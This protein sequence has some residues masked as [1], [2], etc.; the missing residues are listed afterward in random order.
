[1]ISRFIDFL[2]FVYTL[3][4]NQEQ[5]KFDGRS[6]AKP[7]NNCLR[8]VISYI[9]MG[10][11]IERSYQRSPLSLVIY[12]ERYFAAVALTRSIM[13]R[14]FCFFGQHTALADIFADVIRG[15]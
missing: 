9:S 14:R 12:S 4:S 6:K 10:P 7:W 13:K 15:R 5:R 2:R 3:S 8:E 1:M 11:K